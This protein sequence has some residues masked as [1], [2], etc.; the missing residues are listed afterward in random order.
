[1][2]KLLSLNDLADTLGVNRSTIYFWRDNGTPMPP[3]V[4]IGKRKK[5]RPADVQ[6]WMDQQK[7]AA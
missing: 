1:M 2:E 5:W 4:Q 6:Q 3:A 7:V